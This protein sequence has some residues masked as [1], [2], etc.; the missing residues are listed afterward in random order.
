MQYPLSVNAIATHKLL[1][2]LGLLAGVGEEFSKEKDFS[3]FLVGAEYM[4]EI[5]PRL[6]TWPFC[7]V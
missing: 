1:H 2:S 7:N 4:L 5:P 3:M 6:G